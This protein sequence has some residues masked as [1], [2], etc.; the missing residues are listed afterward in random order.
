MSKYKKSYKKAEPVA[1]KTWKLKHPLTEEQD[2][3]ANS[4]V[5]SAIGNAVAGS[6]KSTTM[7]ELAARR[8]VG[9]KGKAFLTLFSKSLQ[10]DLEPYATDNLSITTKHA[11]G[12]NLFYLNHLRPF[13]DPKKS[14]NLLIKE[15]KYDPDGADDSKERKEMW[16]EIYNI[17]GLVSKMKVRL[18]EW[19]DLGVVAGINAQYACGATDLG[20]A[21]QLMK[22]SIEKAK[23]GWIDF[24]DMNYIPV[25]E[26][27]TFREYQL[28]ILDEC[29]DLSPMDAAFFERCIND[30]TILR[31]VGDVRQSIMGFA[32]ADTGMMQKLRDKFS[33]VDYPISYT[34]RCGSDIVA[35]TIA[36]GYH[37]HIKAFHANP[38]GI[39][40]PNGQFDMFDY[41]NGT[42]LLARRNASLMPYAIKSHKAGRSVSVLG[43]GIETQMLQILRGSDEIKTIS[44]LVGYVTDQQQYKL[45]KLNQTASPKASAIEFIND[46][47]D[48]L[49]GIIMECTKIEEVEKFIIEIFKPKKDSLVFSSIHRSKGREADHVVILDAN[50]ITLDMDK[51][52]E[53]ER[54]QEI[55]LCY[56]AYTRAKHKLELIP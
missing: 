42:M 25:I 51:M 13:V 1:K 4:T 8:M 29:Q 14:I 21:Q 49:I 10:Q 9:F 56:V 33:C 19:Q 44:E 6:G 47:Y 40:I 18:A 45:D 38:Q 5:R 17:A 22:L 55:N 32:G 43:G 30:E 41:A 3:L 2:A 20:L 35:A 52:N 31:I 27:F 12:K 36:A 15:L 53:E 39:F 48:S 7:L 26:N 28:A 50:K 46:L 16:Q 54:Q 24:D 37:D 11:M 34:F 23:T